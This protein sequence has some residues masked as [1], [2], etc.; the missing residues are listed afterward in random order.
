[1]KKLLLAVGLII[2]GASAFSQSLQILDLNNNV[3]TNQT[4]DLW[5]DQTYGTY[6]EDFN[7]K[8]VSGNS[9][10]I[11]AERHQVSLAGSNT[12]E[13]FCWVLCYGPSTNIS[14]TAQLMPTTTTHIFTSHIFHGGDYGTSTVIYTFFDSLNP[15]DSSRFTVRWHITPTGVNNLPAVTGNISN[16]F[17]NPASVNTTVNYQLNNADQALVKVYDLLGNEIKRINVNA[18]DG[19]VTFSVA[20]LEQG[21]YFCTFIADDKIMATRK[22]TVVH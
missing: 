5:Y 16:I 7:V 3:I 1:M 11:L 22:L 6:S 4:I 13:L 12:T 21:I 15:V 18:K 20:D 17:P 9:K 19:S 8:N 14:P 2:S 10:H